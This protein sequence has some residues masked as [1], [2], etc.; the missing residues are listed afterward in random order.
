MR[1]LMA[2]ILCAALLCLLNPA[3]AQENGVMESGG[4]QYEVQK[5]G[6]A[7]IV[8]YTEESTRDDNIRQSREITFPSWLD[9]HVVTAIGDDVFGDYFWVESVLIPETIVFISS[10]ALNLGRIENIFVL[11]GNPVYESVG[12]V[13]YDKT[14]RLLHSYPGSRWSDRYSVRQGTTAI[15]EY[16][17]YGAYRLKTIELPET[18]LEIGDGAF[19]Y[20]TGLEEAVLP[21]A[22]LRIGEEAFCYCQSLEEAV[23]PANV[24]GIG[25]MA[26]SMCRN[27]DAISVDEGNSSYMSEGGV[28]FSKNGKRLH[29]YPG[30]KKDAEYI[31]PETVES[32]M[33][34]AFAGNIH[35]KKAVIHAGV[36]SIDDAIFAG[37]ES[38]TEIVVAEGNGRYHDEDGVLFGKGSRRLIAYPAGREDTAYEIPAGTLAIEGFA[39]SYNIYLEDIVIPDSVLT[40]GEG[41]FYKC[42]GLQKITL[43]ARVTDIGHHSFSECSML[44]SITIPA[45]VK[46]IEEGTFEACYNLTDIDLPEGLESIGQRA[47]G[48]CG[49]LM[50]VFVPASV[51][52]IDKDAFYG[53]EQ[54][55]LEVN[56]GSYGHTFA[57]EN[58]LVFT[59]HPDW[60]K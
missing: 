18:L 9:G 32:I 30:N 42:H 35:L 13:L 11:P 52:M 24:I 57:Q 26:F 54:L 3:L 41:A 5:D 17:F 1:R 60:L 48:W 21:E 29:A 23:I 43:P 19:I 51:T 44:R 15:G 53:C 4:F 12:G 55:I 39:F 14:K 20:C 2:L 59:L 16:A 47:F 40:L 50:G 56:E 31:V 45:G 46:A 22:L 28:L 6:T 8:S 38:L 34:E 36:K 49:E 7:K 37:C 10:M 33:E 58:N 25:K 27:L